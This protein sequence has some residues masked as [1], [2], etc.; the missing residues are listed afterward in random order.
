[1]AGRTAFS[2]LNRSK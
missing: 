2:L 1:M